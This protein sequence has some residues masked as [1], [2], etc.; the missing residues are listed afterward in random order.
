MEQLLWD[1]MGGNGTR[2]VIA[3]KSQMTDVQIKMA[4]LL[5]QLQL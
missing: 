3:Q 4:T 2:G 1:E 5:Q